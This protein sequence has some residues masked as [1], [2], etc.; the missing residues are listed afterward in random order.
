MAGDGAAKPGHIV[1]SKTSAQTVSVT[2]LQN[3][4]ELLFSIGTSERWV[5]EMQ[6]HTVQPSNDGGL[7]ANWT[8][9]ANSAMVMWSEQTGASAGSTELYT[10]AT[11]TPITHGRGGLSVN[12]NYR[13]RGTIVTSGTSGTAQFMWSEGATA[14]VTGVIMT[15][16]S[17][18]MAHKV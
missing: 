3:D 10:S 18:L 8:L 9:P 2:A 11:G 7:I 15:S 6:L 16:G 13:L 14:N 17:W 12:T 5:W 1:I 4:A